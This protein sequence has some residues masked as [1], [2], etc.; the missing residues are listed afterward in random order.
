MEEQKKAY[1]EPKLWE[2]LRSQDPARICER[3]GAD[4]DPGGF[5]E[6]SSLDRRVRIYP[7][8]ERLESDDLELAS[9]MEYQL[10]L[11]SYLL[12]AQNIDPTGEWVSEKDLKGGSLFFRGPHAVPSAPLERQFGSDAKG[13]REKALTLGGRPAEFGDLSM[14]FQILPRISFA[15]VLWVKDEEFPAR[16]TFMFDSSIDAHLPLDVIFAMTQAAAQK[17]LG[18]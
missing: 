9:S 15:V 3:S 10:L 18:E 8:E 12:Y 17:L 11:V 7:E 4:Y 2:E 1:W 5:Y 14:V 16:V 6:I 13:F